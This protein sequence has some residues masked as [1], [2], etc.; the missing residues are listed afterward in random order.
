MGAK[1]GVLDL[2]FEQRG[3]CDHEIFQ[4]FVTSI[5]QHKAP[6]SHIGLYLRR[7]WDCWSWCSSDGVAGDSA[8][9]EPRYR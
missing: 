7:L 1:G 5:F 6:C 8:G 3:G 4:P 2:P 9:F